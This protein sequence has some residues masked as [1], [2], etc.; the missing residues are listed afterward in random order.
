MN[1]KH[2]GSSFDDFLTE[3]G[4]L[5]DAEETAAKRVLAYQLVE[6]MKA[7]GVTK[8]ELARRLNT[9]R[10]A[11]DRLLSAT[12]GTTLSSLVRAGRIL[13]MRLGYIRIPGVAPCHMEVEPSDWVRGSAPE[14]YAF[15][16]ALSRSVA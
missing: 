14:E 10:M 9:S 13:G 11:V 16:G 7:H 8:A 6:A 5:E 12:E 2:I 3:E 1:E 15:E 4:L